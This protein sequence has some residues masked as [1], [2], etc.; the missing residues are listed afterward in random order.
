VSETWRLLHTWDGAPGWNMGLDEAFLVE[1]SSVPTLRF[2]TWRP[3][4]LSLG[5]F[6]RAADVPALEQAEAAVRRLTGGGAIHHAN[7][8]TFSIAAPQAHPLYRGEVK[9]SYERVHAAIARALAAFD[10]RA[11]LRG[12]DALDSDRAEGG[13]CF[14]G[15]TDV[16]LAWDGKKGVGSAQRRTKGRVLH[17]GSIKLGRSA[18]DASVAAIADHAPDVTPALVAKRMAAELARDLEL[19]FE[20]SEPSPAERA[21]AEERAPFFTSQA[22]LRRR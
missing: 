22:F 6:Q 2:Y 14:E 9:R 3:E 12:A 15:S 16:D 10:V 21:H 13:M 19:V 1:P 7:E 8:L 5:Y 11:R 20:A 17:H 4:T 18:L